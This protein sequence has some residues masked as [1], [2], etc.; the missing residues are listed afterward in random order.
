VTRARTK[1][2]RLDLLNEAVALDAAGSLWE[3]KH[4]AA[5]TGYS[6][7]YL[8]VSDCPKHRAE[9][10]G[11]TGRGRTFYQP[12]EVRDWLASLTRTRRAG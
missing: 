2:T 7:E 4:A 11:P 10:S 9:G 12:A 3:A 5:V 1:P 8:R 6:A